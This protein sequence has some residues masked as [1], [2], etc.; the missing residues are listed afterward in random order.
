MSENGDGL[1][2]VSSG[3]KIEK[4]QRRS[5]APKQA[6]R[7]LGKHELVGVEYGEDIYD[8][9]DALIRAV[10]DD[11]SGNPEYSGSEVYAYAPEPMQS[12]HRTKR[13][14]FYMTGVISPSYA[15]KNTLVD[16]G[17]IE[18]AAG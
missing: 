14:Q 6:D 4:K 15:E 9:T 3:T 13:Y 18:T 17:I 16:Y 10:C 7:D 12:F 5:A 2:S 11:L 8:T 1:L